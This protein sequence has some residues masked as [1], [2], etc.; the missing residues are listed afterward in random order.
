MNQDLKKTNQR[1]N[2]AIKDGS[3]AEPTTGGKQLLSVFKVSPFK[4]RVVGWSPF[5]TISPQRG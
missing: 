1:K 5:C 4:I 3:H 2:S